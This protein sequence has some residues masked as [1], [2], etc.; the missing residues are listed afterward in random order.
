LLQ[1][2][3]NDDA[4]NPYQSVL[5]GDEIEVKVVGVNKSGFLELIRI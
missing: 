1:N 5:V 2:F 4:V 3:N